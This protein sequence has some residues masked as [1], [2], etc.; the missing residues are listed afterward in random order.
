MPRHLVIQGCP[1]GGEWGTVDALLSRNRAEDKDALLTYAY[2]KMHD[3]ATQ[4]SDN[5]G[6]YK[7]WIF[8]LHVIDARENGSGTWGK[9][10]LVPRADM[11]EAVKASGEIDA[12]RA[13]KAHVKLNK[14]GYSG[15][16]NQVRA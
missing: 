12:Q 13:A 3:W 9:K 15:S 14:G 8:R 5:V 4:S 1:P 6:P 11:Q 7:N 10:S 2:R 16:K